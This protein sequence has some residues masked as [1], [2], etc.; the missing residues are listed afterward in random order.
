ML[1]VVGCSS[2][3]PLPFAALTPQPV[4]ISTYTAPF[5]AEPILA[6]DFAILPDAELVFSPST[7][8]FDL[9][10][11]ISTNAGYLA[12]YTE[13]VEDE[14]RTA[15][16]IITALAREYSVNPRLLLALLEY[17]SGWVTQLQSTETQFPLGLHDASYAGL[18]YQLS[19]AANQLNRGYYLHRVGALRQL[20]LADSQQVIL[21]DHIN[22]AS[23]ALQFFFALLYGCHDWQLA[24][25]PLG[26]Q[27]VYLRLFGD[28]WQP[29]IDEIIPADLQ[30]PQMHL[31]FAGGERW[32]FTSGPH[33]AWGDGAAWAALDFAPPGDGFGCYDSDAWVLAVADG[34][35]V[36]AEDGV[37]VLDLD[38]DGYEQTGWTVL[39]MHIAERERV[40]AGRYLNAGARIGHPSCEG[41]P[42]SGTH[43]HLVRRYNGAW[44]PADQDLPFNLSGWVSQSFGSQYDGQLIKGTQVVE[45]SGYPEDENQIYW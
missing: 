19:W 33:S 23:A 41:G 2:P 7:V 11:F 28:P 34:L 45:A 44:I 8:G 9:R 14:K 26:L 21:S 20:E 38:S 39:Y 35:V 1:T 36:R 30:Q 22:A 24:V 17:Q 10:E 15:A 12:S 4:N 32:Y 40:V 16:Q 43:V 31:P 3:Q 5:S 42:S 37:V 25:S 27:A 18:Y 13:I 6:P 29:E